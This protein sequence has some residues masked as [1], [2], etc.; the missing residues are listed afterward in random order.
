MGIKARQAREGLALFT[1]QTRVAAVRRQALSDAGKTWMATD[2][3]TEEAD[4]AFEAWL[5]ATQ[6][7][8]DEDVVAS[9]DAGTDD[10][11]VTVILECGEILEIDINTGNVLRG[12]A[13]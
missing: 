5:I 9:I 6:T 8:T 3:E 13:E 11:T 1:A 12:A 4:I 7:I 10:R 2:P